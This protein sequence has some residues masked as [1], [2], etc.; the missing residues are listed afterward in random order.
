MQLIER[1]IYAVTQKLPL[2]HREDIAQELRGLIEDMLEERT[3][4]QPATESE[5][6]TVL[7]DLGSPKE[8]AQKYR[9]TN[10][11][12]IGPELFD[13]YILVLKIVITTLAIGISA[14]FVIQ[15]IVEPVSIL[16]IFIHSIVSIVTSIPAAFGWTTLG[17]AIAERYSTIKAEDLR[18]EKAW[19]PRDL[20]SIPNVKGKINR[21]EPIIGIILY[22]IMILF[23][24]FSMDYFGVWIF[25]EG[26]T[27]TIP[28]INENANF[29]FLLFI[30]LILGFGILK[31]SLK[32]I[33]GRWTTLLVTLTFI[34]NIISFIAVMFIVVQSDF[35]NPHFM[36]EMIQYNL[37]SEESHGFE[38]VNTIWEQ[39]TKW[40]PI[41]LAIG[42]I[43]DAADGL[44]KVRKAKREN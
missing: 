21:S 31:E 15:F 44:F 1:Y 2:A 5:M 29:F 39:T 22:T 4:G 19:T 41:F 43:W 37:V 36:Q 18:F 25:R 11:F 14:S 16:D 32:L 20:P 6:E 27:G 33:Y 26:F 7:L 38:V 34:L 13:S 3:G 35:W 40:I 30:I 10:K 9:G 28:F 42:L 23:F 8:L 12:L 24:T 17:F